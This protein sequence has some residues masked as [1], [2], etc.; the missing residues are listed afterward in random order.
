MKKYV[1]QRRSEFEVYQNDYD[2]IWDNV[3][4]ELDK[5]ETPTAGLAVIWKAAA[6]FIVVVGLG[7]IMFSKGPNSERYADG[8]ALSELSPE[9]AEAEIYYSQL[10]EEKLQILQTSNSDVKKLVIADLSVLDS[11]YQELKHD[12][13]DNADNEEVVNAMIQNYRIK[14]EILEQILEE[15]ND[16]NGQPNQRE[17]ASI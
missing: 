14:L 11:A 16:K 5:K 8:I 6:I 7:L 10:I 15:L 2:A 4:D 9:L 1:E 13:K 3:I 12:L 17:E